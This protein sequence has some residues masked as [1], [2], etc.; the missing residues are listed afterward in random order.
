ME[1]WE[2]DRY[3][4][5]LASLADGVGAFR[6]T[7]LDVSMAEF[8]YQTALSRD[9]AKVYNKLVDAVAKVGSAL[10]AGPTGAA[11]ATAQILKA[12]MEGSGAEAGRIW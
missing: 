6:A 9:C 7:P 4:P 3:G 2:A 5:V 8:C 11:V 12:Q 1:D 10:P